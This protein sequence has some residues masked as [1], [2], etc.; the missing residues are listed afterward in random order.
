[1]IKLIA[2]LIAYRYAMREA[3]SFGDLGI[4]KQAYEYMYYTLTSP[5]FKKSEIEVVNVPVKL[6]LDW[7]VKKGK[8]KA[9]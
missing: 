4:F 6:D 1:M 9:E 7:G 2:M 8:E 5:I 3:K